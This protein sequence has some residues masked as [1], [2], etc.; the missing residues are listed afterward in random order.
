MSIPPKIALA[1]ITTSL[2]ITASLKSSLIPPNTAFRLVPLNSSLSKFKSWL[3]K[4]AAKPS[5]GFI[6]ELS[7][8]ISSFTFLL[9]L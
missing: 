6:L 1:L 3:L 8:F 9:F 5:S 4:I 7:F 2:L